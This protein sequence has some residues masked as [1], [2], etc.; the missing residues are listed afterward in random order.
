MHIT[1]ADIPFDMLTYVKIVLPVE[2]QDLFDVLSS[3]LNEQGISHNVVRL[4]ENRHTY[5]SLE[6]VPVK[7]VDSTEST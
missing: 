3:A 6:T 2:N 4:A 1:I 5:L 7:A